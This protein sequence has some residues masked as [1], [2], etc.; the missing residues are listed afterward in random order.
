[1][2]A[3]SVSVAELVPVCTIGSLTTIVPVPESE[4]DDA[5]A[6]LTLVPEFNEVRTLDVVTTAGESDDVKTGSVEGVES[7]VVEP[8]VSA[9]AVLV[10]A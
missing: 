10:S 2:V 4:P 7:A 5:A 9:G 8:L 6:M 3:V 1:M